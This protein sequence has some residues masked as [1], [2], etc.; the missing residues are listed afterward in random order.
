MRTQLINERR[1]CIAYLEPCAPGADSP[2]KIMLD[3]L[4]LV[5]GRDE[6]ADLQIDSGRVSRQHAAISRDGDDYFIRDLGSTNG[7]FLNGTRIDESVLSSGDMLVI[8]DVE[9]T[10]C[11]P[12]DELYR[13]TA[14]QVLDEDQRTTASVAEPWEI[15]RQIRCLHEMLAGRA[16]ASHYRAI[17]NLQ[18]HETI[19]HEAR[20]CEPETPQVELNL[21]S[22]LEG[23]LTDRLHAMHRR[24]ACENAKSLPEGTALFVEIHACELGGEHLAESLGALQAMLG[25]DRPLVAVVPEGATHSGQYLGELQRRLTGFGVEIACRTNGTDLERLL[26]S[27]HTPP[28]YVMVDATLLTSPRPNEKRQRLLENF[29]NTARDRGI[30]VIAEGLGREGDA[31]HCNELGC[32][33]GQGPLYDRHSANLSNASPQSA[34]ST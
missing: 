7:T 16:I 15:V 27:C 6:S 18:T 34:G 20:D 1:S 2:E 3:A 5:M 33:F 4:P 21:I 17:V 22:G 9:F 25:D 31:R 19:G 29:M 11:I 23:P 26:D 24:L 32:T 28:R 13:A 14:T 30:P 8:A 10:F 12:G